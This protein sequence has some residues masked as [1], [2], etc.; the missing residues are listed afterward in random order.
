MSRT[1]V[2][3]CCTVLRTPILHCSRGLSRLWTVIEFLRVGEICRASIILRSQL[4][5]LF[6]KLPGTREEKEFRSN[7]EEQEDIDRTGEVED[8]DSEKH[9]C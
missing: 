8:G 5:F 7:D 1:D 6:A 4:Y 9:S 2:R 3:W